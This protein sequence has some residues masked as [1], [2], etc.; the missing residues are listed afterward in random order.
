VGPG[1]K[2]VRPELQLLS[3]APLQ[4]WSVGAQTGG[5]HTLLVW[6]QSALVAQVAATSQPV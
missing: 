5:L 3:T 4:V 1:A 6:S 2:P